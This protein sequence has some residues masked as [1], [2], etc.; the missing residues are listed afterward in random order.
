[1]YNY[2]TFEN[3]SFAVSRLLLDFKKNHDEFWIKL[4]RNTSQ[5]IFD[6][7]QLMIILFVSFVLVFIYHHFLTSIFG[8]LTP[9]VTFPV[10]LIKIILYGTSS[11]IIGFEFGFNWSYYISNIAYISDIDTKAIKNLKPLKRRNSE[12]MFSADSMERRTSAGTG[13]VGKK[14]L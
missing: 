14:S 10:G 7:I 13:T 5:N 12:S 11:Y 9:V 6:R 2:E 8:P 3:T 1:M 4:Q